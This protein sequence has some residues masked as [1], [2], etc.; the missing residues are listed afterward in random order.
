MRRAFLLAFLLVAGCVSVPPQATTLDG[1]TLTPAVAISKESPGG[2]PVVAVLSDGTLFA[3]GVGS[4]RTPTGQTTNVNKV[5]RSTDDG[6][7]WADVTP[8]FNGQERSNDGF[9]AAGNKDRVYAANVFSLTLQLFRSDDKGKTWTPLRPPPVP[10]LLH[11]HW[12]LP[13]GEKTVHLAVEALPPGYGPYLAGQAPPGDAPPTPNEGMWYMR[14]D[15]LGETWT[16]P[17]QIDPIV[18]FA[19]QSNMVASADGKDLYVQRFEQKDAPRFEPTYERGHWYLVSSHDAGASWKRSE[20]FDLTSELAAAIPFLVL[21]PDGHLSSFWSQ[22]T[23][24]TSKLAYSWSA[25]HGATWATPRTLP[26]GSG[27]QSMVAGDA[28]APGVVA[29]GWFEAN[30]TGTAPKVNASWGFWTATLRDLETDAPAGNA[31]LVAAA[32][33]QGNICPKGPACKAGED[34]RLLDYPWVD[35]GP[36]GRAHFVFPSTAWDKPSSFAMYAGERR[37]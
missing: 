11:R 9:V 29:L 26:V 2:E 14:S 19:G 5:W 6:A 23:N 36:D 37:G 20:M 7:S 12:V 35:V 25:D 33:H 16:Q 13:V 15:D 32:V 8:P 3:Q 4:I 17:V 21:D 34:R 24:G 22:E 28:K 10:M 18:N 27:V 1:A 30:A 31:S